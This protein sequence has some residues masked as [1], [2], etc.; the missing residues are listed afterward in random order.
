[1]QVKDLEGNYHHWKLIGNISHAS[2]E[3]KSQLHLSARQLLKECFPTLQILEEVVIP[4]RRTESLV[5][6][7]YLPLNKKCIEVHGEQHYKFTRF[8]HKDIIGFIRHKKR[9]Q[10]KKEWCNLNGIYYIELPYNETI[11]EWKNRIINNENS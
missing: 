11:A 4:L 9:D 10:D 5:L 6:D 7:F 2:Y 3:N 8:Y 1:M